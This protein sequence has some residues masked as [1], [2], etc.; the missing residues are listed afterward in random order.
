MGLGIIKRIRYCFRRITT[1]RNVFFQSP[2]SFNRKMR[3]CGSGLIQL[4]EWTRNRG[5]VII[6]C[7]KKDS[8]LTIGKNVF[9]NQNDVV[10]CLNRIVI[11]DDCMFGPNVCLY[12]HDHLYT[13]ERVFSHNF[14]KGEIVIGNNVWVGANAVILRGTVIGDG[15]VIGAG[16]VIKGVVPPHTVVCSS[17][18]YIVRPMNDLG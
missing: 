2:V 11:G 14:K 16:T 17:N 5:A 12:D 10:V 9:F 8:R 18:N 1:P 15:A 7:I 6:E 13:S 3:F 4:G